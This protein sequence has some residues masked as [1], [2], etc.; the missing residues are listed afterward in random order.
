[1]FTHLHVH[2]HFSMLESSA[3]I[4]ELVERAALLKMDALALTDKYVM[5]GAVQFYRLAKDAGLKPITGCEICLKDNGLSHLTLLVKNRTGYENL[6]R[7]VSKSHTEAPYLHE[8]ERPE[9]GPGVPAVKISCLAEFS[10]GLIALSGC[11]NGK[12]SR[13]LKENKIH[14]AISFAKILFNIFG[15]DFYIEIQRYKTRLNLHQNS[16]LA[17]EALAA[18]S[19]KTKIPAAATNN[20]HYL[21]Q[22]DCRTYSSLAKIKAMGAK[23][24]PLFNIIQGDENYLKSPSEM[25]LLFKDMPSAVKNTQ[26]IADK[27]CFDFKLGKTVLPAFKTPGGKSQEKYLSELCL[28]GIKARFGASP[29]QKVTE[30][31][32][33]ELNIIYKTGFTGYFLIVADIAGFAHKNSIPICGKGSS[34]GSLVSY[35]LK[36]SNVDPVKN[37]LYF[38][39]FLNLERKEPPDIDIDVSA[40]D[41]QKIWHY[42]RS[43]YGHNSIARVSSFATTKPRAAIRESGRITGM[44]KEDVDHII[45][46]APGYNRFYTASKMQTCLKSAGPADIKDPS[47]KKILELSEDIGGYIRHVSMH[48]S[49]F[50]VSDCDLSCRIPLT[51]SET[52]QIMSQYDMNSI[53]D[54]GILKIDL[55]NSLSLS[56]ISDVSAILEKQRKI[57]INMADIPCN[58]SN[59]FSLMQEGSTLGVFQLESFGIRTLAR[60]IKPECLNDITLLISLYR[61]GPQQSGMVNNFIERKFGREKISY[62][63]KD[64][65]PLL[66]ETFGVILY[67]EQAMQAAIKIAGYSLSEADSLRKAMVTLSRE[68]MLSQQQR[69]LQGGLRKGYSADTVKDAFRMISKFASYGFVKAH[70]AAYADI[71]YKTCFLKYH[72]PAEFLATILTNNSGYYSKMQYLEEARRLGIALKLPDINKSGFEFKVENCGKAIRSPLIS[73][74]NLGYAGAGC[75]INERNKNGRFRSFTDFYFRVSATCRIS[76]TAI[77]NLIKIGAFDFTGIP[78]KQLLND[79]Y[80]IKKLKKPTANTEVAIFDCSDFSCFIKKTVNAWEPEKDFSIEEKL[81]MQ[82]R[83]LGFYISAHPLQVFK[84]GLKNS[85]ASHAVITKSGSFYNLRGSV[86]AAG[87][88]ISKRIE[89]TKSGQ[90]MMFC[91]MEDEDGMYEA[92]FFPLIYKKYIKLLSSERF[93]VIKGR[94]HI[95]DINVSLISKEALGIAEFSKNERIRKEEA[96]KESFLAGM[97]NPWIKA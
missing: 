96:I 16:I 2:S 28:E 57:K 40:R 14:E 95:K 66:K 23:A 62:I 88:I 81:L 63:H 12:I 46:S 21:L 79:F 61:P 27:C 53:D 83:L 82:V 11:S 3:R 34:A 39:R 92:V 49:A 71:S 45:K 51:L 72:Y 85:G 25:S 22:K 41:R 90:N 48:P 15:R 29:P 87:I 18:F 20:V 50:I 65:E 26:I 58:D 60:K 74:K 54:I 1:M 52:G 33:K 30:R 17:S 73:V 36:I 13:L 19:Q 35:L 93:I 56:L 75:I 77:E 68:K 9:Q 24:D 47:L 69:F 59:V 37:N 91:T 70:A 38:E 64:L 7:L 55:I 80:S 44:P 5:G 89:N 86:T 67:Q 6:C 4:E 94:L 42:L 76:G 84:Q 97:A 8:G 78:T 32:E 31:L 43:R 10:V